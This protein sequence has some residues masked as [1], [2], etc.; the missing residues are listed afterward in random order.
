M[1]EVAKHQVDREMNTSGEDIGLDEEWEGVTG[2][3]FSSKK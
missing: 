1:M 3:V 2:G